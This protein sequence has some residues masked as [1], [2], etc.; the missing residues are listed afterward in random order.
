MTIINGYVAFEGG[1]VKE[2][3]PFG[4]QIEFDR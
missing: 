4:K 3:L 1:R 2:E